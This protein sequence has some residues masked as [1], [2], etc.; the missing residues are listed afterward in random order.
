MKLPVSL[1]PD[2]EADVEAAAKWYEDRRDGL[3]VDFVARVR[4]AVE[5]IGTFPELSAVLQGDL[6]RARMKRF[7]Y[8]VFYRIRDDR[9]EVVGV[10]HKSRSPASWRARGR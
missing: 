3:G 7:P 9:I 4:A 8:G 1:T 6:R 2:A 10:F 5:L